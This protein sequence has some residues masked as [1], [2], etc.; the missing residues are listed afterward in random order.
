MKIKKELLQAFLDKKITAAILARETG[1]N[2]ADNETLLQ[3]KAVSEEK[4]RNFVYYFDVDEATAMI[5]CKASPLA[6][7]V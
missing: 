4:A 6:G 7:G 2:M 1:A 5:N 3:G